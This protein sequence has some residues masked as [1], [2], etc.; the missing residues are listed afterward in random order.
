MAV[1][2]R[3]EA[4]L[5]LLV[6][7][8]PHHP[9]DASAV[10]PAAIEEDDAND[11]R[12]G[13]FGDSPDHTALAGGV[14][15]LEEDDHFQPLAHDPFLQP[16]QLDLQASQLLLVLALVEDSRLQD[17]MHRRQSRRPAPRS[18]SVDQSHRAR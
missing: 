18:G 15:A 1:K 3:L 5:L 10:V 14:A 6:A 8:E 9:L 2:T 12:V 7:A 16:D 13:P 11:P 17:T 4:S